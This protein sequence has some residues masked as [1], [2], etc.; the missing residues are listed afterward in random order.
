[1]KINLAKS[2]GFCFGVKRAIKIARE[3]AKIY[4]KIEI[5]EDMAHNKEVAKDLENIGIRKITHLKK[6]KNKVLL[7]RAHG[8]PYG[9]L[10]RARALGCKIIDDTC[11]KVYEI[12]KRTQDA[13]KKSEK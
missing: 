11:P 10:K 5:M 1:M 4:P 9:I 8:I 6:G 13:E 12:H 2:A 3:A 7:I